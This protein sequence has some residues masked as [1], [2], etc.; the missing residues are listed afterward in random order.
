[1]CAIKEDVMHSRQCSPGAAAARPGPAAR[2]GAAF[3]AY[4]AFAAGAP[5][6]AVANNPAAAT[7]DSSDVTLTEADHGW[8]ASVGFTNLTDDS[9]KISVQTQ[10]PIAGCQ[11][12]TV[13]KHDSASV[14]AAQHADLT[15]GA[16]SCPAD[17]AVALRLAVSGSGV[18]QKPLQVTAS[19]KGTTAIDWTPL[20]SFPLGI[21]VG[22]VLTTI[23]YFRWK[24]WH[25]KRRT[26]L[27]A[28][29]T[30]TGLNTPLNGLEASW[31]F[32]DSV[33]SNLTAASGLVALVLGSSDF[34]KA[35][36]GPKPE[37][38]VA[39]ATV[40]GAIA[41]A[42][43][44]TAGVLTLTIRKTT[45]TEISIGG[46]LAGTAVAL[47]AAGGQVAAIAWLLSG[48]DLGRIGWWV[49]LGAAS[50]AGVLL[51]AYGY[52]STL[53]LLRQGTKASPDKDP[54]AS[55]APVEIAA[56]AI[57]AIATMRPEDLNYEHVTKVIGDLVKRPSPDDAAAAPRVAAEA[58]AG[59]GPPQFVMVAGPEPRTP[60]AHRSAL[61]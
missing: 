7:L 59:N 50:L 2:L 12:L 1:V 48:V 39:V 45:D 16:P 31:S 8:T 29:A 24:D 28:G 3:L 10:T 32:K 58:V 34:L 25:R 36:L 20:I 60:L 18:T 40:A 9:L 21:V 22:L 61:P 53:G 5:A 37:A 41:V 11:K 47:G 27:S 46:L 17:K 54:L 55:P 44:G 38:V 43:V 26:K 51:V 4:L 23:V 30:G 42:L 15:V 57:G 14:P 49:A 13:D 6:A 56:A 35:A 33:A 52:F 19:P